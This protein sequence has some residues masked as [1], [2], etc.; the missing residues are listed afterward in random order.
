MSR[1]LSE[2]IVEA[3]VERELR[4]TIEADTRVIV[5][6]ISSSEPGSSS[7]SLESCQ[8]VTLHNLQSE[9]WNITDGELIIPQELL[10]AKPPVEVIRLNKRAAPT[11]TAQ[12][13]RIAADA[14]KDQTQ[15]EIERLTEQL[16]EIERQ[17]QISDSPA[18]I[19][20]CD[21]VAQSTLK[22]LATLKKTRLP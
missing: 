3:I 13:K 19:E 8:Q 20:A 2:R 5:E 10:K 7:V 18:E 15:S 12:V 9:G 4:G 1:K 17:R 22:Q 14:P 6:R 21:R 16:N 11:Q